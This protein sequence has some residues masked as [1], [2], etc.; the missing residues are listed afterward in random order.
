[1]T[2]LWFGNVQASSGPA[3][4]TYVTK[5]LNTSPSA[6]PHTQSSVSLG[7]ASGDRIVVVG[8]SARGNSLT[9][10]SMT[11]GGVSATELADTSSLGTYN[12][13]VAMYAASVPTGT[14]GNVVLTYT[15]SV[16][17]L[18]FGIWA[19]TGTQ[20]IV[21]P[22]DTDQAWQNNTANLSDFINLPEGGCVVAM[23]ATTRD[24][25]DVFT[26]TGGVSPA[27]SEDWDATASPLSNNVTSGVHSNGVSAGTGVEINAA[28]GS[29]SHFI[30]LVMVSWE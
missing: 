18:V 1:M 21:T 3:T 24:I 25:E 27:L 14:S 19:L 28:Q 16:D 4:I 23:A 11:I 30:G 15:G 29:G 26:W 7:T 5:V 22:Y 20:G 17:S 9:F 6:S 8:V 2:S 12:N 13:Q 10:S